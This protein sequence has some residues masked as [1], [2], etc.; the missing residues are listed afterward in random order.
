MKIQ[1]PTSQ[2]SVYHSAALV[3]E[4]LMNDELAVDKAEA[5]VKALGVMNTAYANEIKR[6][7]LE[8]KGLRIIELSGVEMIEEQ[9]Q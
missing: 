9:K 2:K 6:S 5:A 8:N 3:Y 1:R 4:K 7:K